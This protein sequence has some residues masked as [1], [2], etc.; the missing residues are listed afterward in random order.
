MP[1]RSHNK[2]LG[3]KHYTEQKILKLFDINIRK[4]W[5]EEYNIMM[6]DHVL[7]RDWDLLPDVNE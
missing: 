1:N 6:L 3:L 5:F 2:Q 4:Y 7:F